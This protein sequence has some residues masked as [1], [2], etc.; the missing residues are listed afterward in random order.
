MTLDEPASKK[1]NINP[2]KS[3]S[4][5]YDPKDINAEEILKYLQINGTI[6]IEKTMQKMR[7]QR[8]FPQQQP[9]EIPTKQY[10]KANITNTEPQQLET[11][12]T[13]HSTPNNVKIITVKFEGNNIKDFR[14]Y[15]KLNKEIDICKQSNAIKSAYINQRNQLI[16]KTT[17]NYL[18]KIQ[19]EWPPKA[20]QSGIKLVENVRR[21]HAAIY[22]VDQEFEMN[23]NDLQAEL[24]NKYN[25]AKATRIV[26]KKDNEPTTT[27]KITFDNEEKY[28]FYLKNGIYIGYTFFRL[29]EWTNKP[30]ILQCYKCLRLGHHQ[31]SCK[32]QKTNCLRCSETHQHSH[33]E[34]NNPLKCIN[35][36]GEHAA[37]SKSC[38]KIIEYTNRTKKNS[39]S[40]KEENENVTKPSTTVKTTIP[41]QQDNG[42]DI[43]TATIIH[44]YIVRNNIAM[45]TFITEIISRLNDTIKSINENPNEYTELIERFFG[46]T[47][48]KLL[49]PTLQKYV[50]REGM[51]YIGNDSSEQEDEDEY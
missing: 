11:T 24:Y 5:S 26:K 31:S 35:C 14:N 39:A 7:Q 21:L 30:S 33:K 47:T 43:K 23:D 38:I 34:C 49:E 28:K 16:I 12:H 48:S 44:S 29:K 32:S 9:D 6:N 18:K 13:S 17:E 4:E 46:L 1:R 3:S 8:S 37:V 19:T 15:F 2:N 40:K 27:V 20:F 36:N 25:I 50:D 22:K 41:V 45:I 10:D 51:E 42:L